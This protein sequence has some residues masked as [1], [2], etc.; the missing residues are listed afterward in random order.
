MLGTCRFC[1]QQIMVD[2]DPDATEDELNILA[3]SRC[4]CPGAVH[5]AWKELVLEEFNQNLE[6]LFGRKPGIKK[7]MAAAGELVAD[8]KIK[9]LSI[10]ESQG[11][12]IALGVKDKGLCVAIT[13]RTKEETISYG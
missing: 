8:G 6:V 11:K 3:T 2:A 9:K 5:E 1:G 10:T 7:L 4:E 13:N 12:T